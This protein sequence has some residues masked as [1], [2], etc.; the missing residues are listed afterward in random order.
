[1]LTALLLHP[2]V[3]VHRAQQVL[4]IVDEALA[5][6]EAAEEEGLAAVGALGLALLDPGA[7]TVLAGQFA[8][9]GTHPRLLHVLEA[10]VALQKREVLTLR[11]RLHTL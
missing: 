5:V 11:R 9:R 1:V 2:L 4:D 10:D 7:Q 3:A 8:A 6:G